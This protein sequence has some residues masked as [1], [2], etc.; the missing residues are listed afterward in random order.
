M[1]MLTILIRPKFHGVSPPFV[2]PE[3]DLGISGLEHI[4][5]E[6]LVNLNATVASSPL[7]Y[8]HLPASI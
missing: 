5:R 4:W 6:P 7:P 3:A 8:L 1:A 2:F